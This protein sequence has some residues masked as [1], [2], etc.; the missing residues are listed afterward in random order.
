MLTWVLGIAGL[1]SFA[2]C[3]VASSGGHS[4]SVGNPVLVFYA[5]IPW[6]WEFTAGAFLVSARSNCS[7]GRGGQSAVAWLGCFFYLLLSS[8]S[9]MQ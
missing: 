6:A 8:L 4:S 1:A 9:R 3:I 5:P 7:F 2:L